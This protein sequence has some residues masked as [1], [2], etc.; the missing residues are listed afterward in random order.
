MQK[1]DH[2]REI[3]LVIAYEKYFLLWKI[4]DMLC[5]GNSQF[6]DNGYTWVGK[7]ANKKINEFSDRMKILQPIP[8]SIHI[9]NSTDNLMNFNYSLFKSSIVPCSIVPCSIVPCSIVL[10]FYC[11]AVLLFCCSISL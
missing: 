8:E 7:E 6:V 3:S 2:I 4:P 5:T 11:S 9:L 1:G 10:L